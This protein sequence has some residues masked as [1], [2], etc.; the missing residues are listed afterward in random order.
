MVSARFA[1]SP[2]LDWLPDD[3][4]E[5]L[6]GTTVHQGVIVIIDTGLNLYKRRAGLS[7]L[8]GNQ[9]MLIIPRRDGRSYYPSP[10][11]LSHPTLGG[12][13]VRIY[14][15]DGNLLPTIDELAEEVLR[16]RGA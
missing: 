7:W 13:Q 6:L 3:T 11:I 5:S 8:I 2:D 10:D 4:E 14:D 1:L 9:L 16:L 12:A 15:P